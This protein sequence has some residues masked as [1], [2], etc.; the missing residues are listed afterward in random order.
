[1]IDNEFNSDPVAS[2]LGWSGIPEAPRLF[3]KGL[4]RLLYRCAIAAG[5]AIEEALANEERDLIIVDVDG[6]ASQAGSTTCAVAAHSLRCV[7]WR[8]IGRLVFT[9]H[10]CTP[11]QD[12]RAALCVTL[13]WLRVTERA[14][15]GN[16]FEA[17]EA[18]SGPAERVQAVSG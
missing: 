9:R 16:P 3:E 5:L 14:R 6:N 15:G 12:S 1:M 4:Y 7:G 2:E 11:L 8:C 18:W 17:V 10:R 13:R